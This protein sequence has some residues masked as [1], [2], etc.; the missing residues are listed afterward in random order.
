MKQLLKFEMRKLFRARVLYI[1]LGIM[2]LLLLI[3]AGTNKLIDSAIYGFYEE[4]EEYSPEDFYTSS[5]DEVSGNMVNSMG[6][7]PG[8]NNG[9]NRMLG[10]LSNVYVIMVLGV[11]AA[12]FICGDF[13][14]NV[15]KNIITKGYTRTEIYFSKYIITLA[16]SLAFSLIA[17]LVSF[18]C[19]TF[20]WNIGS[21]WSAKVI[22]LIVLQLIS[23]AAYSSLF[24][25]LA[26]WLK[27]V[28]TT[29]AACIAIPIAMPLILGLLEL[30]LIKSE[31]IFSNYWLAGN[32]T[33]LS[34]ITASSKDIFTALICSLVYL[35]IFTS[36]GWLIARKREV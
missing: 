13:G 7:S 24:V 18:L 33:L 16:V 4:G 3:F 23:V 36:C 32:F 14:N 27:R 5:D 22:L 1:C 30:L 6:I 17:M 11:F 20:M 29:L 9:L 2:V 31:I 26:A 8:A 28:G 19:G 12:V 25:F 34:E 10:S 21:G 15:V 35:I